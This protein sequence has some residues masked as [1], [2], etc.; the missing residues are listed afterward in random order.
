MD[1]HGIGENYSN[2]KYNQ[3]SN[4]MAKDLLGRIADTGNVSLQ[5]IIE[6]DANAFTQF[7]SG[8]LTKDDWPGAIIDNALLGFESDAANFPFW[9]NIG[10]MIFGLAEGTVEA[11]K[12][13]TENLTNWAENAAMQQAEGL[14]AISKALGL[15]PDPLV[16][17]TKYVDPIILD[18]DGN[19]IQITSLHDGVQFDANGDMI[20]TGT[21]WA[22]KND[23]LL[24][25]DRNQ[26]G[27]I[28]SGQ[29]LF[30]D[31]T[32]LANGKKA[33]HGFEALAELDIGSLQKVLT[34]TETEEGPV[35]VDEEKILGAADGVF[36]KNDLA[37][38]DV[39]IWMDENQDGISQT[40]ELKTLEELNIQSIQIDSDQVNINYNDAIMVQNSKFTRTDGSIGQAGSFILA[41]NNF[42]RTF[43][44]IEVSQEAKSVMNISGS[45]WVRDFQEAVTQSPELINYYQQIKSSITSSEFEHSVSRLLSEW[46]NRFNYNSAGDMA[47]T[48]GYGLILSGP[49]DDQEKGWMGIAIKANQT[50]RDDVCLKN[51]T[52][53]NFV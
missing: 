4:E 36:D 9:E 40:N 25:L 51:G 20:K 49:T 17:T 19:G 52:V 47:L 46:G 2:Q 45:G 33:L 22:G 6:T 16:K 23:G 8:I 30:G 5:S 26:N 35:I 27:L 44:P 11:I 28:D 37:F 21:A 32:I 42:D 14:A 3:Y 34:T 43:I 1:D 39:R 53:L 29:E 15:T 13:Y 41:Q 31:E 24:V 38:D 48:S 7:G 18:L 10:D 12:N 50:D